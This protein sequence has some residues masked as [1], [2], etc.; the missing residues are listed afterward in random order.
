MSVLFTFSSIAGI[1][2]MAAG[3]VGHTDPADG[4]APNSARLKAQS[5]CSAQTCDYR[6]EW[7]TCQW[8]FLTLECAPYDS[9]RSLEKKNVRPLGTKAYRLAEWVT[10]LTPQTMY[11]YR[12]CGK[13]SDSS[14]FTCGPE[15][16][17]TTAASGQPNS[18][19]YNQQGA[20]AAGT[21][22][23]P[24]GANQGRDVG[25]AV[26]FRDHALYYFG[27]TWGN[28]WWRTSTAAYGT[29]RWFSGD[30]PP[31]DD[32][33]VTDQHF[34][35]GIPKQFVVYTD[36]EPEFVFNQDLKKDERYYHWPTSN[37]IRP[38]A[39]GDEALLFWTRGGF[40]GGIHKA[41]TY[42]DRVRPGDSTTRG[43][44]GRVL[45]WAQGQADGYQPLDI[46]QDGF[47]FFISCKAVPPGWSTRC[48][49]ARVSPGSAT[50]PAAYRYYN[51][52]T[53]TWDA[54]QISLLCHDKEC[55]S[56]IK[57]GLFE[58]PPYMGYHPSITW[59]PY[60]GKYLSV[61]GTGSGVELRIADQITG[62]W[63]Q[64]TSVPGTPE[65]RY[66]F[67]PKTAKEGLDN[68][69]AREHLHLRSPDARTIVVSYF[70]AAEVNSPDNR[71]VKL[72]KIELEK[73][74]QRP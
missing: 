67:L 53:N 40:E 8:V 41:G 37:F 7:T 63:S 11:R 56:H 49:L 46:E 65:G 60:L 61:A 30:F 19:L 44:D 23:H 17:F 25:N 55:P 4:I 68:Y 62:P 35:N 3:Y 42:L 38:T 5:T 47:R 71:A 16:E 34:Q 29:R 14:D 45:M 18:P 24:V 22:S 27:D 59:N 66:G 69:H 21:M 74:M 32:A 6:Y 54:N 52:S 31:L 58:G 51:E 48:F 10:D 1:G 72:V 33:K 57:G 28:G 15:L 70:H 9:M 36:R 64:P 26:V 12:V 2:L 73:T 50:N 20:V 39:G 13:A 43:A